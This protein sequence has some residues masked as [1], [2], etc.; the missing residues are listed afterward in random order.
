MSIHNVLVALDFSEHS[1]AVFDGAVAQAKAF[2]AQLHLAHA[3]EV[4]IYRGVRYDELLSN[5]TVDSAEEKAKAQLGE[6]LADAE[7][8]GVKCESHFLEGEARNVLP[9]AASD[10]STDLIVLGSHGQSG[11]RHLLIGSVTEHV[12]RHAPC[13]VLVIHLPEA[14][15]R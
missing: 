5:E 13:S 14:N 2:G 4:L 6:F 9:R 15:R 8:Q 3:F 12:I 11:L 1:R 7:K 10:L